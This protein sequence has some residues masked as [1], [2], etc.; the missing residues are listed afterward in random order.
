MFYLPCIEF[1]S[2]L[3]LNAASL[4]VY[5][6]FHLSFHL[7]GALGLLPPFGYC[8]QCYHENECTALKNFLNYLHMLDWHRARQ[9]KNSYFLLRTYS[10]SYCVLNIPYI[11]FSH[12][13]L[14]TS[15]FAVRETKVQKD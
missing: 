13:F 9:Y 4:Y 5:T 14:I 6:T 15:R 8:E 12:L 1:P 3:R 10:V 11:R 2:F 7:C